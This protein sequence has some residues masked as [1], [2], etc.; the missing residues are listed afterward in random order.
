M[1]DPVL[2][3]PDFMTDLRLFG[4]QIRALSAERPVMG[5]P[6]ARCER[7]ESFA[8]DLLSV[9]PPKFAV[10]GQGLGGAVALELLRRAEDRV[11]RIALIGTSFRAEPPSEASDREPQIIAASAGRFDETI[12]ELIGAGGLAPGPERGAVLAELMDMARDL[13]PTAF[14]GQS[15]ALQR[16]PDHQ[17]TLRAI[18]VPALVMVGRH[19]RICLPKRQDVMAELIRGAVFN[20]IETSGRFPTLEA[21]EA[22]TTALRSWL[23]APLA[24]R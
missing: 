13:G 4:P 14:R 23:S 8:S 12:R 6:V 17:A 18:K 15:R 2:F 19:D 9:A 5:L 3:L 16:R 22:V 24:P 11:S 21:P 10:V 1:L 20:V 7:I